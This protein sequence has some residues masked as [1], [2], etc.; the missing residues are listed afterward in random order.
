MTFWEGCWRPSTTSCSSK[1]IKT[2]TSS[3]SSPQKI[4]GGPSKPLAT[5]FFGWCKSPS[6]KTTRVVFYLHG[7]PRDRLNQ[8]QG[9]AA[10]HPSS[11][12]VGKTHG[13]FSVT[14]PNLPLDPPKNHFKMQVLSCK[15]WVISY[16]KEGCRF[17][18]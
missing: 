1:I 15:I 17:P 11:P 2:L 5:V 12:A 14:H 3:I 18:V 6:P 9:K 10:K 4:P 8:L 7:V 16:K 13:G